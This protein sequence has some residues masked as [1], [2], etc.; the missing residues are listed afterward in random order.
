MSYSDGSEEDAIYSPPMTTA[1]SGVPPSTTATFYHDSNSNSGLFSNDTNEY[2]GSSS[3]NSDDY[4]LLPRVTVQNKLYRLDKLNPYL[5]QLMLDKEK[6]HYINV[7][8]QL[9]TDVYEI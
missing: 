3:S 9:Y 2:A 4:Y 7:C 5:I 8:R 6:E 1:V